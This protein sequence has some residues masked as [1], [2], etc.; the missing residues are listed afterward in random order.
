MSESDVK[1]AR[2]EE[3]V[4]TIFSKMETIEETVKCIP[5]ISTQVQL[6]AQNIESVNKSCGLLSQDLDKRVESLEKK[7]SDAWDKVIA[8][9]ITVVTSA[10]VGGAMYAIANGGY[11]G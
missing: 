10:L 3:Q 7:P 8:T 1:I 4:K 11:F 5:E 6:I 9:V 2:L